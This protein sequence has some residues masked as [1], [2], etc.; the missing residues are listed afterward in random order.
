[1]LAQFH[2]T[3]CASQNRAAICGRNMISVLI[4]DP[5]FTFIHCMKTFLYFNNS[6]NYVS[7]LQINTKSQLTMELNM[8]T[9]V[10]LMSTIV[11]AINCAPIDQ[12]EGIH[13][14]CSENPTLRLCTIIFTNNNGESTE[15]SAFRRVE[16]QSMTP[17]E[18]K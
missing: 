11:V 6:L 4:P 5:A 16:L 2:I 14:L 7:I 13:T 3:I 12:G 8:K 15:L 1:V 17:L 10:V 18:C 9:F